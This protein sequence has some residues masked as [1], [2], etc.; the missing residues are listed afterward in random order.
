MAD[1]SS[2]LEYLKHIE[3]ATEKSFQDKIKEAEVSKNA[4]IKRITDEFQQQLE[5]KEREINSLKYQI[6][7][8]LLSIESAKSSDLIA[9]IETVPNN[10]NAGKEKTKSEL[11]LEIDKEISER[12]ELLAKVSDLE[13]ELKQQR[14]SFQ[15][16]IL[17]KNNI[18]ANQ[19]NEI[20]R[21]NNSIISLSNDLESIR[22]NRDELVTKYQSEI[23]QLKSS[24]DKTLEEWNIGFEGYKFRISQG[25]QS[26][27]NEIE[28]LNKQIQEKDALLSQ[29]A[30]KR[31]CHLFSKN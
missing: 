26:L 13:D 3:D 19:N 2:Y 10:A 4:E 20:D 23:S 6:E 15:E 24:H 7:K 5:E 11:Q 31:K 8:A 21:L 1:Y 27:R 18:I 25:I 17:D 14:E 22:T 12:N 28:F 29:Q 16:E 30:K 9:E